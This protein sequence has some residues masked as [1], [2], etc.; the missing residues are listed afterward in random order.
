MCVG[1][2]G[3]GGGRR[4]EGKQQN[5]SIWLDTSERVITTCGQYR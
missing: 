1:G 2:G 4:T 3:G 5:I